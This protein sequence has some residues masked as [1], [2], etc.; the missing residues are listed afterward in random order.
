MKSY[1]RK[2]LEA[3][4][5]FTTEEAFP[6]VLA[7]DHLDIFERGKFESGNRPKNRKL[8]ALKDQDKSWFSIN[9]LIFLELIVSRRSLSELTFSVI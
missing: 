3:Y 5:D 1:A 7:R 2:A 4:L 9:I 6:T 8:Q